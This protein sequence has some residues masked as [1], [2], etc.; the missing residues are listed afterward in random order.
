MRKKIPPAGRL[1]G[2]A[3]PVLLLW[4]CAAAPEVRDLPPASA[5]PGAETPGPE[6]PDALREPGFTALPPEDQAY[7]KNLSRAFR[8]HDRDFLLAQG[9]SQFEAEVKPYYDDEAYLALLYR[10]GPY[11]EEDPRGYNPMPRLVLGE[12][13]HIEYLDYAENDPLL[14]VRGRLFFRTGGF[15]PCRIVLLRRLREP[16]IIGFFP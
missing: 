1:A 11:A 8:D 10:I 16:K 12:L 9:E 13:S 5:P 2:I 6:K 4:A 15:L 14:E 7:L 3:V